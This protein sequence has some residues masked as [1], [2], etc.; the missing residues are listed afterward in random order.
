MRKQPEFLAA[1]FVISSS[2]DI[3]QT[4]LDKATELQLN[5]AKT[6]EFPSA[7]MENEALLLG[8]IKAVSAGY[9]LRGQLKIMRRR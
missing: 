6:I 9:P 7:L 5:H 8:S 2:E 3:S 1:D 4:W